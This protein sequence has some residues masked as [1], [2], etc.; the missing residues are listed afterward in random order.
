MSFAMAVEKL[1]AEVAV[2]VWFELKTVYLVALSPAA[3]ARFPWIVTALI[4]PVDAFSPPPPPQDAITNAATKARAQFRTVQV[5][6][7]MGFGVASIGYFQGYGLTGMAA[8]QQRTTKGSVPFSFVTQHQ[9]LTA[10]LMETPAV[11]FKMIE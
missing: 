6:I 9:N 1:P 4:F 10:C 7:L 5:T 3:T 11:L 2:E 8:T